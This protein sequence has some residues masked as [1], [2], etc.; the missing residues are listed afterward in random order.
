ME[1]G[2]CVGGGRDSPIMKVSL[3]GRRRRDTFLIGIFKTLVFS[4]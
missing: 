1:T 2:A 3:G 4:K